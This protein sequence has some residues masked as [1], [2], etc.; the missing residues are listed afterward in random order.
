M[1]QVAEVGASELV[2]DRDA[3]QPQLAEFGP[4]IAGNSLLSS[5]S[6]ARGAIRSRGKIAH[7]LAQQVKVF[8]MT[9]IEFKHG[10]APS[11]PKFK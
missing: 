11:R 2:L 4:E 8:A 10:T 3:E 1:R 9:K 6:A 7:G 5:I